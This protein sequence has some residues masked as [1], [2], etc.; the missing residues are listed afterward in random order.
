MTSYAM[1]PYVA[2]EGE[3]LLHHLL[4][5][6]LVKGAIVLV[7][8]VVLAVGMVLIW[9]RAQPRD[10]RRDRERRPGEGREPG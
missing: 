6:L 5:D 3:E 2:G 7:A 9:R 4:L 10:G 8:L 1:T